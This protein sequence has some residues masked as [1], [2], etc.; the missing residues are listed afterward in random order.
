M[1]LTLTTVDLHAIEAAQRLLLS[2]LEYSSLDHWRLAVNRSLKA[3]LGADK[4]TFFL[5]LQGQISFF[6]EELDAAS[7]RAYP[8]RV[9]PAGVRS[10]VWERLVAIRVGNSDILWQGHMD[11]FYRS[12]YYNDYLVPVRAFDGM[13][14]MT[15]LGGTPSATTVA[16]LILHHDEPNGRRFGERGLGILRLLQPAFQ[17]GVHTYTRLAA[18]RAHLTGVLDTL[19]EGVLLC[20]PH[21]RVLHT[22]AALLRMLQNDPEGIRLRSTVE[23]LAR[24]LAEQLSQGAN[25]LPRTEKEIRTA[26]ARY[27]VRGCYAGQG[28][29]GFERDVLV[30]LECLTPELPPE[31][32]L[33][34]RFDLSPTEAR[35]ALLLAQGKTNA[36]VAELMRIRPNTARIHTERVRQKLGVH[37]RAKVGPTILH[38]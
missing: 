37:S 28:V 32:V 3:L 27:R 7:V 11:E 10:S 16:Q 20:D 14:M 33:C 25:Q 21:G 6:S 23:R 31:E 2:P 5:P 18:H 26:L 13:G 17:A 1:S 12:E 35:V 4:V 8:G 15:G 38:S 19:S 22:N 9:Q 34:E 29:F 30:T 24:S 36:E